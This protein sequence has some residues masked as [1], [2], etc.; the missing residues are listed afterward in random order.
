M[1]NILQTDQVSFPQ[2]RIYV[3][4]GACMFMYIK[5]LMNKEAIDL[6]KNRKK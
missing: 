4:V 5:Q 3:C 2:L 6:K 1:R